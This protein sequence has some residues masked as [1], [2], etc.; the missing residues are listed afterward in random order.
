MGLGPE[1]HWTFPDWAET[2]P[3][4]MLTA[5]HDP[6]CARWSEALG[7]YFGQMLAEVDFQGSWD[8]FFIFSETECQ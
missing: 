7:C 1:P 2:N 4:H 3:K 6:L 8:R 5:T